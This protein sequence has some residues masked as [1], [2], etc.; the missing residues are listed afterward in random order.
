[1]YNAAQNPEIAKTMITVTQ[2]SLIGSILGNLLLV[3]GLAMV[4]GGLNHKVQLFS[5][6][7]GQMNGSRLLLAIVDLIITSA[8]HHSGS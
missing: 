5:Q 2:A 7:A 8:V 3:L 1:M 6:D 4:W